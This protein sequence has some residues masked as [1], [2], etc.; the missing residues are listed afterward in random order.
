MN[1]KNTMSNE[2][3][4]TSKDIQDD[5]LYAKSKSRQNSSVVIKSESG[6]LE[7]QKET[8]LEMGTF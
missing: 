7:G 1:F 3:S 4:Q 8:D 2:M 6:C 5:S